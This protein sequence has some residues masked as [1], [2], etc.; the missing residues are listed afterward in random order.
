MTEVPEN[1]VI[2]SDSVEQTERLAAQLAQR[3]SPGDIVLLSGELGS[4]KTAFVRGAARAL[5]VS[6]PVTSPTYAI[7]NVYA[8]AAG[9]IAHLDLYRLD[10]LSIDDEAVTDD[11]L[12][13]ERIGFVEWPHGELTDEPR[14]RAVVELAHLGENEREIAVRWVR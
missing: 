7:G 11:F 1:D 14:L 9:E 8:G 4:G 2:V 6:G 12:T 5:G 10:S 13:P 3:L